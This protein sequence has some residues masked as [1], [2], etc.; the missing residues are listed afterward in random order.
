MSSLGPSKNQVS[1]LPLEPIHILRNLTLTGESCRFSAEKGIAPTQSNV[2][3]NLPDQV[4][5]N[6]L[7]VEFFT[8]DNV[9]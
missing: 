6:R 1:C 5:G 9:K 7:S 8:V 3:K 4:P 2:W